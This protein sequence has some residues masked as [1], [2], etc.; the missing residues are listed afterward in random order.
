MTVKQ[1]RLGDVVQ[2]NPSAR[3]IDYTEDRVSFVAMTD[4][5][6]AG[7]LSNVQNRMTAEVSKGYTSFC[8]GDVLLAKI[9]PCFENGKAAVAEQL[10]TRLAFGSTEFHVLR[11]SEKIDTRFLFHLIWNPE[12]RRQ[13]ALR[14]TGSAGQKRVPAAFL[15]DYEVAL[16]SLPEQRRI[17]AILDKADGLRRKR[18]EANRLANEF[19]RACFRD[20]FGDPVANEKGL[21]VHQLGDV[22]RFYAGNSLPAGEPFDGQL[23]GFLHIK[24]GD[25]N[26]PGNETDIQVAREWSS[27]GSGAIIAPAGTI[28]IPKR[29]GAIATNKKRVLS[30]PCA[31]DPNLMAIGPGDGLR[32]EVLLEWFKQFDLTSITSGSAVPQ[33]NKGDLA[34]L[35][36]TV[37]PLAMQDR[38]VDVSRKVR[39]AMVRQG[40]QLMSIQAIC[41]ALTS[42]L[43]AV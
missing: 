31:L 16:P 40:E 41:A 1:V 5:S 9:T 20:M 3:F 37:P 17:A 36:I 14:M 30:R 22:C 11:P 24:V 7:R 2:I 21:P 27:K 13:G 26:L 39:S 43:L 12:F 29:G 19:L 28:L 35:R 38:F 15:S 25:M 33:L 42:N 10:P 23:G 34:P 6:D 18:L 8:E 32:Q 4:V